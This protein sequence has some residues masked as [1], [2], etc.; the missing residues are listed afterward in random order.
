MPGYFVSRQ[1][2]YYS[3]ARAV[4]VARGIDNS[5]SDMLTEQYPHLGEG[6]EYDDPRDAV[7]AAIAI[8]RAWRAD[9][10]RRISIATG[11]TGGMFTELETTTQQ[12]AIKWAAGEFD[13]LPKCDRCGALR[14]ETWHAYGDADMGYFCSENCADNAA[15][16]NWQLNHEDEDEDAA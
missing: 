1:H 14:S 11:S 16:D 10:G 15:Y 2:Y 3:G 4:E 8:A 9:S 7:Q 6:R 12:D 5:G 13:R